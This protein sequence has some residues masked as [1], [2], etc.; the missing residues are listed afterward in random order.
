MIFAY[1][2]R[3]KNSGKTQRRNKE[4]LC[5]GQ[6]FRLCPTIEQAA[7]LRQWIGC[8]RFVWNWALS[9]QN[10]YATARKTTWTEATPSETHSD[11]NG[12]TTSDQD[13]LGEERSSPKTS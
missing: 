8:G 9:Q 13:V 5:K 10:E 3:M 6:Q 7:L 12:V 11:I 2:L 1:D 4:L